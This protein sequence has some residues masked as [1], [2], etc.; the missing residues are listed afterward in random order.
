MSP[1]CT[2]HCS[3]PSDLHGRGTGI[4]RRRLRVGTLGT[5]LVNIPM[6][7]DPDMGLV[8]DRHDSLDAV[9]HDGKS[10]L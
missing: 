8:D 4:P 10:Y 7:L 1:H 2:P 6:A 5:R 9:S 3:P